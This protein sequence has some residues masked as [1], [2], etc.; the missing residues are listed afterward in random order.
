VVTLILHSHLEKTGSSP[1]L[2]EMEFSSSNS[3]SSLVQ[4]RMKPDLQVNLSRGKLLHLLNNLLQQQDFTIL[5]R[6][7]LNFHSVLLPLQHLLLL[8]LPL[9]IM[10]FLCFVKGL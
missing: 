5:C 3:S 2:K 8:D 7:A 1:E 9:T 10:S 6:R 4:L